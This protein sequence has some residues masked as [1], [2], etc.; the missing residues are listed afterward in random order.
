MLSHY[1]P[2]ASA[3]TKERK[4]YDQQL[5]YYV[6]THTDDTRSFSLHTEFTFSGQTNITVWK[7]LVAEDEVAA[8]IDRITALISSSLHTGHN[9]NA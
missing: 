3:V 8:Y 2:I 4:I 7:W 6:E 9:T 5:N 1:T